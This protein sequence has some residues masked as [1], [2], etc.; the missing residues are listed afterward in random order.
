MVSYAD[1]DRKELVNDPFCAVSHDNGLF[2]L[3]SFL[4]LKNSGDEDEDDDGDGDGDEG[5]VRM[6]MMTAMTMAMRTMAVCQT[7]PPPLS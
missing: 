5:E 1:K 3:T 4:S 2:N 7:W 6:T